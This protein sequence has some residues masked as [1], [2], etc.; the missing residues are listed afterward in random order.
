MLLRHVKRKCIGHLDG[1]L[2]VVFLHI[3][4]EPTEGGRQTLGKLAAYV[5]GMARKEGGD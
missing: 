4:P 2:D 3:V 1:H 5:G